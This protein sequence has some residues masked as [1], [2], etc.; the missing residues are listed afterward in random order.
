M[1]THD[2]T[3]DALSS[4]STL[5]DAMQE[6]GTK[7]VPGLGPEWFETINELS[8]E[9]LAFITERVKQDLQTQQDLLQAKGIAD[10]QKIQA[11]FF[12]KATDDYTAEMTKLMEIGKTQAKHATPV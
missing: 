9:M 10:V 5:I 6:A 12:K 2:K 3:K 11:D 8:T 4:A 7:M 1:T